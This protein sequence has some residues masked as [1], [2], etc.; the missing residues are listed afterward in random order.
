MAE[1]CETRLSK[2]FLKK[3]GY[4]P[5]QGIVK[6]WYF[7]WEDVDRVATQ[8]ANR[9]TKVSALV[10]KVGAKIYP[11]EG[12]GKTSKANHTLSIGEYGKGY[13]HT[14]NFTVLYR[15]DNESERIQELVDGGKVG[16]IIKRVDGGISG[17][18]TYGIVGYESGMEITEDVWSSSENGG[19]TALTVA[20]NEGEDEGTAVKIW[21]EGTL[22]DT[23]A[24]IT[25]NE[26]ATV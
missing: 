20:T 21:S 9:G 18:L 5:K 8:L 3:C 10:L 15:G 6:K 4:K 26:Y 23:E 19:T 13:I 1:N 2:G 14:D 7:N 24:W 16:T 22:A 25:A 11:A 12:N 17:E